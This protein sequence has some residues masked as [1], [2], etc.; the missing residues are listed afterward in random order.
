[1]I[2]IDSTPEE[3]IAHA[4]ATGETPTIRYNGAN[5]R[6]LAAAGGKRDCAHDGRIAVFVGDGWR[7]AADQ[8]YCDCGYCRWC[9]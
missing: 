4:K 6:V 7:V 9:S 3:A 2:S 5:L 8:N 1:M